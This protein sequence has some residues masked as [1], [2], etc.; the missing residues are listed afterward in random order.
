MRGALL[1]VA[2]A[3]VAAD[4]QLERLG[5]RFGA[6]LRRLQPGVE[7][8]LILDNGV[9]RVGV[10]LSRGGAIG[11]FADVKDPDSSVINRHDM[12]REVQLSYY[13]DPTYYNPPTAAYPHGACDHLFMDREW[14]WNPIGAGDVDGN[15]GA[16]LSLKK[17]DDNTSLTIV[18]RPLQWACH[19]VSCECEFERT[20]TLQGTGVKVSATLHNH[21]TDSYDATRKH[22]QEQP[23]VYSIG[24]LYRL[25]TYNGS[26]PWTGG[27]LSEYATAGPPWVPG[28]FP[29]TENW[30]ALVRDDNWGMGIVNPQITTF[31][32]G[33]HGKHK[34]GGPYDDST[35]YIAP[36][37][38][39]ALPKNGD[40]TYTFY[41]VLG[42]IG[43]IRSYAKGVLGV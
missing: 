7:N 9:V 15:H 22:S 36:I 27:A 41:L 40:Y 35:G 24:Q 25:L 23:A 42:N 4:P 26:K 3:G 34:E 6:G 2:A 11:Y 8:D 16:I 32:G 30:A 1:A 20:I 19:N 29:A 39:T 31:L 13:A 21:R 38:S 12:G 17:S 14:P 43:T 37:T 28:Q 33:F 18:T 5:Q 10:D